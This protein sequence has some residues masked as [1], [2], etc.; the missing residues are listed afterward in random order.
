MASND[1]LLCIDIGAN[2][3]KAAEFSYSA[4]GEMLLERFAFTEYGGV[5]GAFAEIVDNGA[6]EKLHD[7]L[8]R[9]LKE[10]SFQS[11]KINVSLSGHNA[12]IRF[13]K[14]PSMVNDEKK[15]KQII[16]FEAK[17]A[18]P[19]EMHEVVWDSQLLNV[20]DDNGEIEAM[21]VIVKS[22]EIERITALIESF[23]KQIALIEV[24][25]TACYNA[26]RLNGIGDDNCELILNIGD[27]CSSLLFVDNGRFFVRIIPIAG[28]AIT[29]QISKEFGISYEEAEEMKRRHGFVALGGAYEEPDSEVAATVSKIV[30]NVMTRLHGEISRSINI[31]RSQQKGRKPEKLYLSGGSSVMGFTPRFFSEKLRIPVEYFNP[32]KNI[33]ISPDID[34]E[35]LAD[36]AHMFSEPIGL[37]LRH[38]MT[39]PVEISLVPQS[40]QRYIEFKGKIPYFYASAASLLLCLL[41]TFFGFSK[42]LEIANA[43]KKVAQEFLQ[44]TK[45]IVSKLRNAESEFS[46]AKAEYEEASKFLNDRKLWPNILNQV[47]AILPDDVWLTRFELSTQSGQKK[48]ADTSRGGGRGA[49]PPP[50][51]SQDFMFGGMGGPAPAAPVDYISV[52]LE[53]H[54][55]V[56]N[57]DFSER[58]TRRLSN[59]KFFVFNKNTDVI[60]TLQDGVFMDGAFNVATFKLTLKLTEPI[61][62]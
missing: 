19:F 55:L 41:V 23:G 8:E 22:E 42:Q 14:V 35:R 38:L 10:N 28:H 47:E 29:L 4:D 48:G 15:I 21:F 43:K 44:K 26:A 27:R 52:Y 49:P 56:V 54:G 40:L 61:K 53:G 30:R 13:V 12:Y 39:C 32:F 62:K 17:S 16:E 57:N 33:A 37:A 9:I 25:P 20:A 7:A 45:T 31:Y 11:K 18:I 60:D 3:I 2:S 6:S 34:K 51:P 46:S 36:I 59:S 50:P 1:Y 24:A 5:E 58:F